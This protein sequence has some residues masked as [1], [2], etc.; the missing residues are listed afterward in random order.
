MN[1]AP[2]DA[3]RHSAWATRTILAACR[4]LSREQLAFPRAT[5]GLGSILATCNHLILADAGYLSA[6]TGSAPDWAAHEEETSDLDEL[7]ARAEE[8]ARGWDRLFAEPFDAE[9][10]L[11]LDGGAYEA[12]AGVVVAQALHHASVH[13]E[14][15]CAMLAAAGMKPPDVQVWSYAEATGRSR[16][17]RTDR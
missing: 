3:F 1:E 12:H 11:I 8:T 5:R 10:L 13:R 2:L 9:R 16:D 15:I 17:R 14:Q 7:A 4:G 6:L